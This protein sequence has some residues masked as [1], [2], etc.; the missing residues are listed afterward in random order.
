MELRPAWGRGAAR[1]AGALDFAGGCTLLPAEEIAGADLHLIESL[2]DKSLIRHRTDEAG[3]DRYWLLE[4]IREYAAARLVEAHETD[5]RVDAHRAFFVSLARDIGPAPGRVSSAVDADRY[6]ADRDNFRLSLVRS[7]EV[8]DAGSALPIV[9]NLASFWNAR[10]EVADGYAV[11][12]MAL[13]LEGGSSDDRANAL[14]WAAHFAGGLG[15]IDDARAMLV[16]A[17]SL[18]AA[19][20]A[21]AGLSE[22][23][24][25]RCFVEVSFGDPDEAIAHGERA[26]KLALEVG[27]EHL[28][29]AARSVLAGG[30][31][32]AAFEVDPPDT[33]LLERALEI[34]LA[35][36]EAM[37]NLGESPEDE[38][39]DLMNTA[40]AFVL[41]DRYDEALEDIQEALRIRPPSGAYDAY[42]VLTAA[43]I[44]VGL[45][46]LS[47]CHNARHLGARR[48]RTRGPGGAGTRPP[49]PRT[50]GGRRP[51]GTR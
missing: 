30:L 20:G 5:E 9:R 3:Q 28:V 41:L 45:A 36:L 1:P 34:E 24:R 37:R 27:D 46:S 47:A 17:E 42:L 19:S 44:A 33:A 21:L 6:R 49:S 8:G 51:R 16:E 32:L 7:I 18:F 25:T 10:G 14:R 50:P 26:V 11:L 31:Q 12:R 22:A 43:F 40:F 15:E 13:A 38:A 29:S 4:T 2:L 23:A 39:T 48:V 35:Y